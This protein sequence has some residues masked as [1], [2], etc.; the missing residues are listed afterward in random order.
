[1]EYEIIVKSLG[2]IGIYYVIFF[3]IGTLKTNNSI[4]DIGWG[5]G[6]VIVAWYS[7]IL[8]NNY[9]ISNLILNL[10]VTIWGLR[11]FTHILRRN[12]KKEDFRYAKWRE[13]WGSKV[14][15]RAFFQVYLL[16]GLFMFVVLSPVLILNASQ[17]N[18]L[19]IITILGVLIWIIGF[20]FESVGDYQLAQFKKNPQNKGKILDT[21]LWRYSRHPNYFGEA[22]MWW[23]IGIAVF[24]SCGNWLAFIGPLTIT[25]MLL[26]VSGVPMLEKSFA[27]RPG[28]KEYKALTSIFFPLPPK[29]SKGL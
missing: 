25:Y 12:G 1:M 4:V 7:L 17:N 3:I 5:L 20:Y 24:G 6:F 28:Y 8:S 11:L 9:S 13:E 18:N 29:K 14:V 19:T 21:G 15:I 16:Q 27:N 22:T 23:G 2:I 10:L 26:F